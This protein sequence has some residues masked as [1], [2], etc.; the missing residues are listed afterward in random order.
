MTNPWEAKDLPAKE[1]EKEKPEREE[2]SH[3]KVI[4]KAS[5]IHASKRMAG[6][7]APS[8]STG[9]REMRTGG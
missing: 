6:A 8:A 1:T 5:D 9:A 7:T 4:W 3:M 2:D